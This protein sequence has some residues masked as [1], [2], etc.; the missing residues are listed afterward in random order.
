M[1]DGMRTIDV[2]TDVFAK[3]WSHR[4]EGEETEN[5]ILRRILGLVSDKSESIATG[6]IRW[7]DDVRQALYVL[8]GESD[9]ARIYA[10]VR[11]LRVAG[12]RSVP[13]NYKA[14]V[15]REL[16]YNSSDSEAYTGKNDWFRSVGGIGSGLWALR[17][18]LG[19]HD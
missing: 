7:R 9:L 6:R 8:G 1:S 3:I 19:P 13:V 17:K 4:T 14:I 2:T 16:E 11:K 5:E 15:R 12:E 18:G 10:E